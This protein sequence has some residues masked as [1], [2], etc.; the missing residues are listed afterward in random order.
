MTQ[1][2]VSALRSVEI[3]LPDVAAAEKF[4]G[5]CQPGK[6]M[7][8]RAAARND[9]SHDVPSPLRYDTFFAVSASRP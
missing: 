8:S 6:K 3:G 5:D 2:L 1:P 4:F 7:A 9:Q